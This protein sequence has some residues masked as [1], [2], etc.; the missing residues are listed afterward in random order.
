MCFKSC[1]AKEGRALTEEKDTLQTPSQ[2]TGI[3]GAAASLPPH[4]SQVR[5]RRGGGCGLYSPCRPPS[6]GWRA[7]N[8]IK[9]GGRRA[10]QCAVAGR[11]DGCLG[12]RAPSPP[13]AAGR[14]RH[15]PPRS[16]TP[17]SL[18]HAPAKCVHAVALCP[19]AKARAGHTAS[20]AAAGAHASRGR[21]RPR[22]PCFFACTRPHVR[23][24]APGPPDP[25]STRPASAAR[26]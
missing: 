22:R 26:R 11:R 16:K 5:G 1:A 6:S 18:W 20:A 19:R 12:A 25:L 2:G 13:M 14:R 17:A 9:T 23:A 15:S 21:A 3:N 10:V 7:R 4:P 8:C 24:R